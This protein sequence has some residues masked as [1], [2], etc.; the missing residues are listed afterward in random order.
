MIKAELEDFFDATR[1]TT[2]LDIIEANRT[3]SLLKWA[4]GKGRLFDTIV[5]KFINYKMLKAGSNYIEPFAGSCSM[6][7]GLDFDNM[8]LNDKN[9]KL[10]NF[11]TQTKIRP[12]KLF[13]KISKLTDKYSECC[14]KKAQESFYYDIREIYNKKNLQVKGNALTNASYFWFLNKTGFNGMYRE[15]ATGKFNIPFGKRDCPVPCLSDFLS[16]SKILQKCQIYTKPFETVCSMAKTGDIIYLDPPY[17]PVSSTA[18]FSDYLRYGFDLSDHERLCKVM[19]EMSDNRVY[20]VLSNSS[21]DMTKKIYGK[22]KD[23]SSYEIETTRLI[24]GKASGRGKV[25]ELIIT[26]MEKFSE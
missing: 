20:V 15:T 10:M 6:A 22:L 16:V 4:G 23:F 18:S 2:P 9:I 8:I 11:F 1:K 26:N 19:Q 3:K 21:C 25:K 5:P 13:R 7:F 24:S 17:I 14:D 12:E